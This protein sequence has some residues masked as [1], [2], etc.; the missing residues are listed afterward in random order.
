MTDTL[1]NQASGRIKEGDLVMVSY[2]MSEKTNNPAHALDGEQ[3]VVK[4][5]HK[6]LCKKGGDIYLYELYGAV[7]K[8]GKPYAFLSD[9]L[10]RL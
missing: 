9:E 3:F 7:S 6:P 5:K 8:A 2:P 10:I 1:I 4:T